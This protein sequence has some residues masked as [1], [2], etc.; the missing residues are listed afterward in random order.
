MSGKKQAKRAPRRARSGA[1]AQVDSRTLTSVAAENLLNMVA[2]LAT[3]TAVLLCLL[4]VKR[5]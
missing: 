4:A 1:V 3:S 2:V 5:L